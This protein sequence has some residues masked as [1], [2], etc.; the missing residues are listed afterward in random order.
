MDIKYHLRT[1]LH[2]VYIDKGRIAAIKK[3][4]VWNERGY[5]TPEDLRYLYECVALWTQEGGE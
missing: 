4:T 1:V 2:R 5:L 3:I